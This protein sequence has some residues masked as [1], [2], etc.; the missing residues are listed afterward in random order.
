MLKKQGWQFGRSNPPNRD[1]RNTWDKGLKTLILPKRA[2]PKQAQ[3]RRFPVSSL[4]SHSKCSLKEIFNL[5]QDKED[6]PKPNRTKKDVSKRN[7]TK[8][9]SFHHNVSHKTSECFNLKETL[10]ALIWR[11]SLKYSEWILEN[12]PNRRLKPLG[13]SH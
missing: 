7:K 9:C 2:A 12:K 3:P 1:E 4:V 5:A 11:G 13:I 10:E 8:Y 6:F